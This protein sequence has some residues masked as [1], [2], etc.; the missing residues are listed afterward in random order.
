VPGTVLEVEPD[1]KQGR[2]AY[3]VEIRLSDG[4]IV[5]AVV[6]AST[7]A[8]VASGLEDGDG[9]PRVRRGRADD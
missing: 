2:A 4:R 6:D 5:E 9:W 1:V 7:G 8:V 3:E